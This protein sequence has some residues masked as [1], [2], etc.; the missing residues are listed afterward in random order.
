MFAKISKKVV[1]VALVATMA[2][3]T[4]SV[5]SD[6]TADA[7]KK[8]KLNKKKA[9]I[10]Q[11]KT[12]KLT[13]SAKAKWKSSNTAVATV[14]KKSAKSIKVKGIKK[15]K[16]TITATV[17]GKT[18]KCK[19]TVKAAKKGK[20][21]Y[22]LANETG[23]NPETGES[24]APP[25]VSNYKDFK[26][27]SFAIWLCRATLYDPANEGIDYRGRK[28]KV[29]ITVKN[30]GK[31]DLPELGVAFN[32]TKGGTDGSYPFALHVSAKKL[33][34]KVKGDK[35][36]RHTTYKVQKIKKG[37]TYKW[38]FT[39]TIPKNAINED[40]DQKTGKYYPI[41]MFIPNCKDNTPYKPGDEVTVK[42]C[43]ISLA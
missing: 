35:Q 3:T 1:A 24:W 33:S 19:V 7:A 32:Y 34:K 43:K 39:F 20:V 41:M 25:C 8:A 29:Q 37:K 21:I 31:R 40:K 11:G 6:T 17:G 16:A 9:T 42:A 13:A 28:V 14:S 18:L 30:S 10:E 36:H 26:Y 23:S 12:V 38:T 4:A 15:G 22:N 2:V 5:S 27:S